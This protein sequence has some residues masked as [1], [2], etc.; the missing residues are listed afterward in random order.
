M[1]IRAAHISQRRARAGLTRLAAHTG[2]A[3]A[4][5]FAFVIPIFIIL[6]F[7]AVEF[8][9]YTM[10]SRRAEMAVDFAAEYLSR[11]GD[12]ILQ[13]AE[14]HVVEDIWMIMNPTAYLATELRDGQWAN[15]YSRALAS[16]RFEKKSGC[17]TNCTY[18]PKVVWSF[19]YQDVVEKPVSV[20]CALKV[21]PNTAALDG[22]NIRQG[23]T[24]R[25][26]VIIADFTYPYKPLL[27]GWLLPATELHVNAVKRTRNGAVLDHVPDWAVTRCS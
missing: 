18:E 22:S 14:R 27:E 25:A 17:S 13:V 8:S 26:P 7:G 9:K 23:V 21:V 16:V 12:G 2:G 20:K 19:L 5:E 6:F 1:L 10:E 15:G 24:G 4:L 11:D 3:A